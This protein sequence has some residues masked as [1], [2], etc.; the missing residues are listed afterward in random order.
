MKIRKP[1]I[2]GF[3]S[4]IG[5]FIICILGLST[6]LLSLSDEVLL[7]ALTANDDVEVKIKITTSNKVDLSAATGRNSEEIAHYL[8]Q[9]DAE[10]EKGYSAILNSGLDVSVEIEYKDPDGNSSTSQSIRISK[11]VSGNIVHS[12]T[13]NSE[14][15]WGIDPEELRKFLREGFE[16]EMDKSNKSLDTTPVS[17]PR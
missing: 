12:F 16:E 11:G 4:A 10:K 14:I 17:D 9:G 6:Y 2:Y 8:A 15:D 13:S 1:F 3:I 5:L 7:E